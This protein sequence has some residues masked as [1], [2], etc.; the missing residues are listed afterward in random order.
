M[1][2]SKVFATPM[3]LTQSDLAHG[4]P[5]NFTFLQRTGAGSR[6]LCRPSIT[7]SFEWNAKH[8]ATLA[9]S[10]GIIY[11]QANSDLIGF[12]VSTYLVMFQ[13][14]LVKYVLLTL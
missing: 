10:G 3:G 8:V 14:T 12:D 6:T 4:T 5:F 1:E 2:V 7:D 11:I 13:S 9:K